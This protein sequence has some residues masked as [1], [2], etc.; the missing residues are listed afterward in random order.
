MMKSIYFKIDFLKMV[1]DCI[2]FDK[3]FFN[4]DIIDVIELNNFLLMYG[5]VIVIVLV[6]V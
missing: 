6:M 1:I 2:G 5:S 4:V 3:K